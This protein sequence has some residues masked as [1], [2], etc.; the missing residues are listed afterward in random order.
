MA[1][2]VDEGKRLD[3]ALAALQ[4]L[5][6]RGVH[7]TTMSR[8]AEAAGL[9]RSTLYWYFP[10]VPAIFEWLLEHVHEE[11]DRFVGERLVAS[12]ATHPVDVLIAW[13]E[14]DRAFYAE[15]D[16]Q[17]FLLLVCQFWAAGTEADRQRFQQL[18]LR[19]IRPVLDLLTLTLAH[20]VSE[21][22]VAPCDPRA[23]VELASTWLQGSLVSAGL[24]LSDG[25]CSWNFVRDHVLAPLR[26]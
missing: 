13:V 10:G 1:R 9:K 8:V 4:V 23:I 25:R 18:T 15:R 21:G 5:R 7:Q 16:L 11:E 3:I 2:P 14:A 26:R 20:G 17:D 22:R 6:D 12:G 19:H 24:G